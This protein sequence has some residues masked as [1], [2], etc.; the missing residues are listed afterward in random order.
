MSAKTMEWLGGREGLKDHARNA[1][2]MYPKCGEGKGIV[3]RIKH[4]GTVMA[5]GE[6]QSRP[7]TVKNMFHRVEKVTKAVKAVKKAVK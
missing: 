4:I 5:S 7:E 6:T 1:N 2:K 3:C